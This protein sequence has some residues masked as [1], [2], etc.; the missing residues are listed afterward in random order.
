MKLFAPLS[1]PPFKVIVP[2]R[3]EK[4]LLYYPFGSSV[5]RLKLNSYSQSDYHTIYILQPAWHHYSEGYDPTPAEIGGQVYS[6][7]TFERF[8]EI[9]L[10]DLEI[11]L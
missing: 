5:G 1:I 8:F 7:F 2:R 6:V 4:K 9:W 11:D 10:E 3:T